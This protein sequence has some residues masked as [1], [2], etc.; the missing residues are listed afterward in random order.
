LEGEEEFGTPLDLVEPERILAAEQC[1]RIPLCGL[2]RGEV[3][4][5]EV[6]PT[7]EERIPKQERRLP[8]LS[9]PRDDDHRER[10]EGFC[11]RPGDFAGEVGRLHGSEY[12]ASK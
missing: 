1:V 12:V 5:G 9:D 7:P 11:D 2:Q 4:E 6:P 3:V 10:F 8:G